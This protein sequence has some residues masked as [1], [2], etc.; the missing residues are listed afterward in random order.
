MNRL[1]QDRLLSFDDGWIAPT[2]GRSY[3]CEA[4]EIS[5]A[6]CRGA[7]LRA[8]LGATGF[9]S[10]ESLDSVLGTLIREGDAFAKWRESRTTL[11]NL[12]VMRRTRG[13]VTRVTSLNENTQQR[14]RIER[15][16]EVDSQLEIWECGDEMEL[17]FPVFRLPLSG[18]E[19]GRS[20]RIKERL[21]S[22]VVLSLDI[23]KEGDYASFAVALN[24][25]ASEGRDVSRNISHGIKQVRETCNSLFSTVVRFLK[26]GL[27]AII[28]FRKS[29]PYPW[30]YQDIK[31]DP[32]Y[33]LG[34]MLRPALSTF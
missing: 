34:D 4:E 27:N 21:R 23:K 5:R 15:Q 25:S 18:V 14:C 2:P 7:S 10:G 1:S 8:Q 29:Q 3:R 16:G 17:R 24:P 32:L 20:K 33:R 12:Q 6:R 22:D 19:C 9:R 26:P 31:N 30:H 28:E 13:T 11:R